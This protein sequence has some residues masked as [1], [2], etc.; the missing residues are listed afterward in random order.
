MT[1][2]DYKFV[3]LLKNV[4]ELPSKM[5]KKSPFGH[6]KHRRFLSIQVLT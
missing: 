3:T 4:T 6:I 1:L 5:Q 2:A